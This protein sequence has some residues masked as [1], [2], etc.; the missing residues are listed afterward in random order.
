MTS[1]PCNS[2]S[3]HQSSI[4]SP[5]YGFIVLSIQ[6]RRRH[7]IV[8]DVIIYVIIYDRLRRH[9]VIYIRFSPHVMKWLY[10]SVQ[11]CARTQPRLQ[12]R[13]SLHEAVTVWL[14]VGEVLPLSISLS[15]SL[16]Q[17]ALVLGVYRTECAYVDG[18]NRVSSSSWPKS[19]K[20]R[21]TATFLCYFS[22]S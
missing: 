11:R 8:Y 7:V 14:A 15:L 2:S 13:P 9:G 12:R 16:S 17:C 1:S 21:L 18:S 22:R 5:V 19:K 3:I 20:K 10:I 6:W 4:A